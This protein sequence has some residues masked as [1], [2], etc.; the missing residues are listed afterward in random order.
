MDN[1]KLNLNYELILNK[2][3]LDK[4]NLKVAKRMLVENASDFIKNSNIGIHTVSP[5][6]ILNMLTIMN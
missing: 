4:S 6:G 2:R 3:Y 1:I 5:E